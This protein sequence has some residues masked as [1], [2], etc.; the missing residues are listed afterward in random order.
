[1]NIAFRRNLGFIHDAHNI[2]T[3]KTA[4]RESWIELYIRNGNEI[5]ELQ[6][7]EEVLSKF[8]AVDPKML[9]FGY[10]DRKRYS[11][12]A[13]LMFQYDDENIGDWNVTNFLQYL[14]DIDRVKKFVA[15]YYFGTDTYDNIFEV[16]AADGYL[17]AEL[18]SQLFEFYIFPECY[19]KLL[20]KE[21]NKIFEKLQRYYSEKFELL[22]QCQETFDYT[23]LKQEKSPF[24]K[25]KKWDQGIK[26]CYV[27]FS[28]LNKYV[29]V[30]GKMG[31]KGWLILGCDF[32]ATFGE[33]NET[34][35]DIAAFGN[36]F[37]DKLRVKIID[38]IVKNGELTLADLSKKLG[39]VNTIVVYHL[40]ILKKEN[41]LLHRYQGRKVLYCLNVSQVEKG[42]VAIKSLCGGVENE[43]VE[44]TQYASTEYERSN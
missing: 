6:E 28:L 31:D 12:L 33:M 41:L 11:V 43:T 37:G 5:N 10:R 21:L 23:I 18:K 35:I 24:A 26:T 29:I 27:S 3:Y 7:L 44:K 42:L 40:D 38:E 4:K 13:N 39:V 19:L 25:N 9:L 34:K 2:I 14:A 17:P 15:D 1:M 30:R 32:F 22:L 36:A 20:E 8:D 16:I